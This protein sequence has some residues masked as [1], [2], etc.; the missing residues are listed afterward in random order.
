MSILDDATTQDR[1]RLL[2]LFPVAV[3]RDTRPD[4]KG[5][6]EEVCY[7]LAAEWTPAQ[8]AAFV[9]QNIAR[10]KQHVYVFNQAAGQ[11]A[12]LPRIIDGG[13]RAYQAEPG[14]GAIY[15]VLTTYNVVLKDPLEETEL[16][17]LWPILVQTRPGHRLV[18]FVPLEKDVS[19]YFE[20]QCYVVRKTVQEG[21]VLA[22]LGLTGAEPTDLHKG[23]KTLWDQGFMDSPRTKFKKPMSMASEAMDEARGI[24]E[25]NPDLYET[26]LDS[27]LLNTF[28]LVNE[29][30]NCGVSAFSVDC[31]RGLLAFPRYSGAERGTDFVIDE[32]LRRNN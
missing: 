24:R 4:L 27:V 16:S 6:K 10:C 17:F 11:A 25:H 20:R 15:I 29:G 32:I 2:D 12:D 19:S 18:R 22:S 28:F 31:T 14:E 21:D 3:F 13:E 9:S 1:K 5:T 8:L 30:Q 23:V 7:A 26:L